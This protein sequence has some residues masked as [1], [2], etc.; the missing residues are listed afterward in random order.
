MTS[1]L[2]EMSCYFC[3]EPCDDDDYC[4]GCGYFICQNCN[5]NRTLLNMHDV[6]DHKN[7]EILNTIIK[8]EEKD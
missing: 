5:L 2:E 3:S 8:N 7:E 1:K 6:L 4:S